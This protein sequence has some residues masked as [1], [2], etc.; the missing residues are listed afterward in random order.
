MSQIAR[1][2]VVNTLVSTVGEIKA[3]QV[4]SEDV[5]GGIKKVIEY[6][7]TARA[8]DRAHVGETVGARV[9]G[10]AQQVTDL[11]MFVVRIVL[12]SVNA[13][14]SEIGVLKH[15]IKAL[16]EEREQHSM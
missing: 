1:L 14:S 7:Q 9:N 16:R 15:V 3:A 5:V 12:I 8:E 11:R 4:S 6:F 13:Q 2:T 10:L